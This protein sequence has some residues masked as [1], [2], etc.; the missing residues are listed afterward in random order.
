[1]TLKDRL[2]LVA[3]DPRKSPELQQLLSDAVEEIERLEKDAANWNKWAP[4]MRSIR[5]KP[6]NLA[7]GLDSLAQQDKK[8]D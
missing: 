6:F 5:R 7:R 3:Q 4:W 8:E 2:R 1:M